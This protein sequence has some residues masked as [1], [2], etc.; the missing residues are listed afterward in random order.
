MITRTISKKELQEWISSL[1]LFSRI[2]IGQYN[3]MLS[4]YL[5]ICVYLSDYPLIKDNFLKIRQILIP[6]IKHEDFNASL[7]IWGFDT[8]LVAK[9]AY[10]IQM[11]LRYQLSY[12]ENPKGGFTVNYDPPFIHGKWKMHK[13]DY[14]DIKEIISK[15]NYKDYEYFTREYW[16]CP[17]VIKEFTDD[18]ATLYCS[19]T[20]YK[21]I[22][23]ANKIHEA[24]YKGDFDLIFYLLYLAKDNKF[25]ISVKDGMDVFGYALAI[26]NI[27]QEIDK[28]DD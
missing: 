23:K 27:V 26:R 22:K 3:E 28:E 7:G 10:D 24:C 15:F 1:D 13:K 8:P 11:I 12:N 17:C 20:V 25:N 21:I 5:G 19:N 14:D 6:E 18:K 4:K 2:Y 9:R 16:R